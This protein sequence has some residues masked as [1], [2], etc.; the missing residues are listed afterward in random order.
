MARTTWTKDRAIQSLDRGG[1][2]VSK[3]VVI[4]VSACDTF[5]KELLA[6]EEEGL[7]KLGGRRGVDNANVDPQLGRQLIGI[8]LLTT[9]WKE[10]YRF[11]TYR[12]QKEKY[13]RVRDK[14]VKNTPRKK[15]AEG[16]ERSTPKGT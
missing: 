6:R 12:K 5:S 11:I 10:E 3:G 15:R 14:N 4:P 9:E 8:Y 7:G 16:Q 2:K 13:S 1:D